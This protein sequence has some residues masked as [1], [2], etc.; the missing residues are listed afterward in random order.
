MMRH[1]KRISSFA[2]VAAFILAALHMPL[3]GGGKFKFIVFGDTRTCPMLYGCD[4]DGEISRVLKE[5]WGSSKKFSF[6]HDP[7]KAIDNCVKTLNVDDGKGK[8]EQ[9]NYNF[10][11]LPDTYIKTGKDGKS[12]TVFYSKGWIA[13]ADGLVSQFKGKK[14]KHLPVFAIH[15]GDMDLF[16]FQ[17][18]LYSPYWMLFRYYYKE[19][20]TWEPGQK[21]CCFP[22]LGNHEG[23]GDP[24]LIGFRACFPWLEKEYGF[25]LDNRIY[26]FIHG[27]SLFVFLSTGPYDPTRTDWTS[28]SPPF[29]QQMEYLE[30]QMKNAPKSVK[31]V[32]V[33]YHKPSYVQVGHDPLPAKHNP[34][35][36]LKNYTDR[37]NIVVF[38]S[39]VHSTEY[40]LVDKIHYLVVGSGGAPQAFDLCPNPSS[41]KELYWRNKDGSPQERVFEMNFMKVHVKKR[42]VTVDVHRFFPPD[43]KAEKPERVFTIK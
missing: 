6:V 19:I 31:H 34:N 29:E 1:L 35:N 14:K 18:K 26:S 24:E 5:R 30:T 32:F 13:V 2:L 42:S 8:T 41:E 9:I 15:G 37:F 28:V 10:K 40:Y 23:W 4:L 7:E 27:N 17:G 22:A 11:A 12:R 38:N 20:L 36:V 33:T 16:G 21:P 25:T 3:Q 39:H 43:F